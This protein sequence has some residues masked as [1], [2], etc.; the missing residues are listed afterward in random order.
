[1]KTNEHKLASPLNYIL[2]RDPKF[3]MLRKDIVGILLAWITISSIGWW[4]LG[5][6]FIIIAFGGFAFMFIWLII[7]VYHR[8]QTEAINHYYQLESLLYLNQILDFRLPLPPM[9]FW[10]LSPDAATI[11]ITQILE[12]KPKNIV[13]LGSG[14]S[15]LLSAYTINQ[16]ELDCHVYAIDHEAKFANVTRN[17]I[18]LHQLSDVT[19]II[20][21]PLQPM[22]INGHSGLWYTPSAFDNISEID[23]LFI[24][25]PPG[26]MQPLS[27]YP[28]IPILFDRL[29]DGAIIVVD[30]YARGDEVTIVNQWVTEHNLEVIAIIPNEKGM[31]VLRKSNYKEIQSKGN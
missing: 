14:I 31:A 18:Q 30:D 16:S 28:A 2:R 20:D 19:T 21:A 27:R 23:L 6:I 3:R 25:G 9:R 29:S 22:N 24:D 1:M 12:H 17:N 7:E 10:A 8:I 5:N 13:E 15:T 11:Y 26:K 4:L